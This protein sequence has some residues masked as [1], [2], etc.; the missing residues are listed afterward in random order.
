MSSHEQSA[1]H[2]HPHHHLHDGGRITDPVCG[3]TVGAESS[4]RTRFE[5]HEYRFCSTGCLEKFRSNP[6]RY[7][8]YFIRRSAEP[9]ERRSNTGVEAE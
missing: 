1:G 5:G 4:H 7:P 2:R 3:M 6:S 9:P 8:G